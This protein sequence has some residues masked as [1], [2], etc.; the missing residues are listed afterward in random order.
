[1]RVHAVLIVALQVSVLFIEKIAKRFVQVRTCS[2][3]TGSTVVTMAPVHHRCCCRACRQCQVRKALFLLRFSRFYHAFWFRSAA[4]RCVCDGNAQGFRLSIMFSVQYTPARPC[5]CS[6]ARQVSVSGMFCSFVVFGLLSDLVLACR[7][8]VFAA[9]CRHGLIWMLALYANLHAF[10][11]DTRAL[12]DFVLLN[13][14]VCVTDLWNLIFLDC[15][16][17]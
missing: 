12:C 14:V 2:T 8:S 17:V 13:V 11:L 6:L 7:F 9:C 15:S 4:L 5:A 16:C 10:V 1:L 3:G